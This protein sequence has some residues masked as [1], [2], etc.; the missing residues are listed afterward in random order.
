[1]A[2][3]SWNK[4]NNGGSRDGGRSHGPKFTYDDFRNALGPNVDLDG[5]IRSAKKN[6]LLIEVQNLRT[7]DTVKDSPEGVLQIIKYD[8][9]NE[10]KVRKITYFL[11]KSKCLFSFFVSHFHE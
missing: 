5:E 1:M 4:S 7:V 10:V 3:R 2:S 6:F 11:V 9:D 8:I